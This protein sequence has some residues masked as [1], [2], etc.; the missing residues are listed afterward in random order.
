MNSKQVIRNIKNLKVQGAENV[1][2]AAVQLIKDQAK[3]QNISEL[4]EVAGE[5]IR[6]R[7]TEPCLRNAIK[8][9]F[10]EIETKNDIIMRCNQAMNHFFESNKVIAAI[11]S[12]KILNNTIIYTHCH[13]STVIQVLHDAKIHK[14]RFQVL[15]TET[16]PLFQGRTTAKDLTKLNINTTYYIDSAVKMALKKADLC[17]LGSDAITSEGIV[18]NKMG[19]DTITTLCKHLDVPVY[20]CTNS[21]KFDPKTVYGYEE[22]IEQRPVKEIWDKP[23]KNL[24]IVNYAFEKI[25]PSNIAGIISEIGV[26]KPEVFVEELKHHYPWLFK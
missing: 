23:P 21:W 16:R 4:K 12:K 10:Y 5:L 17:F 19:S 6:A 24:K 3:K 22:K 18:I 25:D 11:G 20:I 13:S 9:V 14:K 8:Y 15:C 1:A 7:A 26:Y 2:K